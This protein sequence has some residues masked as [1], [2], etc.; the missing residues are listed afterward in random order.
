MTLE[1]RLAE[2]VDV[3][4]QLTN[5]VSGKMVS[6]DRLVNQKIN[7]MET[8]RNSAR[9]E[10]GIVNLLGN[11]RF[12]NDSNL[13]GFP[14]NFYTYFG[15]GSP[16]YKIVIP[17]SSAAAGS[18]ARIAYDLVSI[19]VSSPT[20]SSTDLRVLKVD[21][22]ASV[23]SGD[24][25]RWC[26]NQYCN[27]G[28]GIYSRGI[29]VYAKTSGHAV[30]E[31]SDNPGGGGM[32]MQNMNTPVR[33]WHSGAQTGRRMGFLLNCYDRTAPVSIY[34]AAPWM[35]NGYKDSWPTAIENR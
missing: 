24:L 26:L 8:W 27:L 12:N 11:T 35:C 29:H 2:V 7:D 30:I 10:F 28:Q 4:R 23:T 19:V 16:Q 33:L 34:I 9:S 25:D 18:D 15:A 31:I 13:D 17:D 22:L 6:I 20:S 14:D 32:L 21:L 3:T 1:A 5:E